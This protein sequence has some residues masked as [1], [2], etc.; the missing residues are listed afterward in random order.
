MRLAMTAWL[1]PLPPNPWANRR[2]TTVSPRP[3]IRSRYEIWSIIVLPTTVTHGPDP[4]ITP[5]TRPPC[6]S[7][8]LERGR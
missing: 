5:P 1:A 3:G 8:S 2:P 7:A 6:G 4:P